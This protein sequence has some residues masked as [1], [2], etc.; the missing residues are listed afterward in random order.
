LSDGQRWDVMIS[1]ILILVVA[2][3]L[4]FEFMNGFHDTANSIATTVYTRALPIG[5]AIGLAA[6]MNFAGA[7]VSE[8]VAQTISKGLVSVTLEDYVILAALLGAITWLII[9]WWKG[10]P[11]S[12]SHAL[13]GSLVGAAIAYTMG[14]EGVIWTG[15]MQKVIIPMFTSPIIGFIVAFILIKVIFRLCAS[16]NHQKSSRVFSRLQILSAAAVAFAHGTNDAQKTMGIITLALVT[17]GLLVGE[18]ANHVPLWVKIICAFTMAA[19]T[20]V[21][22]WRIMKTMGQGVTRLDSVRG[23]AA[24]TTAAAVIQ[25]MTYLHAPISTTQAI[26]SAI[27]GVGCAQRLSAVKWS[28]A[29]YIAMAWVYTIP[30]SM[31]FGALFVIIIRFLFVS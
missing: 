24:E 21:G 14:V 8:G 12:C 18:A 29:K 5:A 31:V 27:M 4:I 1:A 10:I 6:V 22:G 15:L 17:S 28:K 20:S 19:G 25:L 13:I 2:A 16:I 7:F 11:I 3:A 23:F 9:T 26:S 30:C